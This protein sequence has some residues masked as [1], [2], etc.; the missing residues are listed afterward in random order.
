MANLWRGEI[1][2][3]NIKSNKY[4]DE[5]I[6]K[7]FLSLMSQIEKTWDGK[8]QFRLTRKGKNPDVNLQKACLDSNIWYDDLPKEYSFF[9]PTKFAIEWRKQTHTC[10]FHK[11]NISDYKFLENIDT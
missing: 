5:S 7:F 10:K 2:I 11:S 1:T 9:S 3:Q 8:T 6:E 4:S